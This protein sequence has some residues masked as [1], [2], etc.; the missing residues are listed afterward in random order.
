MEPDSTYQRPSFQRV[1]HLFQLREQM[2]VEHLF[3]IVAIDG[4]D[5]GTLAGLAFLNGLDGQALPLRS[6]DDNFPAN[7]CL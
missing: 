7:A 1:E 2:L 4:F 5:A 6:F 3:A